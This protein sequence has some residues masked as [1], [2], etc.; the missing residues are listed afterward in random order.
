MRWILIVAGSLI[1]L[2]VVVAAVGL[3]L[4]RAHRVTSRLR[5]T[6]PPDSVWATIRDIGQVASWWPEV[7]KVE[8]LED[9][10]GQERWR[11]SLSGDLALV[12]LIAEESP[13]TRLRTV[14][15]DT[16]APFGGEW[17]YQIFPDGGGSILQ[18]TEEGWVSNPVFRVVSRVMGHHRTMDAYLTAL[19]R[20][21]GSSARPE[22]E[23]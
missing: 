7:K 10:G 20:R 5:L 4:P 8:R 1:G 2:V 13:P 14:I 21:F 9:P 15:E 22:H 3:A 16:G 12:L 23:R 17:I 11:E 6:Q 18:V 19:A